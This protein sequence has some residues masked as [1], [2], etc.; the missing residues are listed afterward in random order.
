V[1]EVVAQINALKGVKSAVIR[2]GSK[3]GE[4]PYLRIETNPVVV[5]SEYGEKLYCPSG[6][7][8]IVLHENPEDKQ[9]DVYRTVLCDK[10]T[11]HPAISPTTGP[12]FGKATWPLRDALHRG[13]YLAV[14]FILC[15]WYATFPPY[16]I[17]TSQY[18]PAKRHVTGWVI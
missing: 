1:K 7:F 15:G 9:P 2:L 10:A 16:R 18:T 12:M 17:Q 5:E 6:V 13:D 4:R 8:D 3:E 14:A 11:P